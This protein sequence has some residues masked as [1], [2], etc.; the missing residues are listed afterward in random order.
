MKY[1]A[2]DLARV[3]GKTQQAIYDARKKGSL[4]S[5]QGWFDLDNPTNFNWCQAHSIN[6]LTGQSTKKDKS[7]QNGKPKTNNDLTQSESEAIPVSDLAGLPE[8][9]LSMT[10]PQLIEKHG[11]L[12][13]L[14]NY[15]D[16]YYKIMQGHKID[17][18]TQGKRNELIPRQSVD[19]LKAYVDQF[20]S[21]CFDYCDACTLDIIPIVENDKENAKL[22]IPALLK[23]ALAK[24]AREAV[25]K[26]EGELKKI[27][28]KKQV[29]EIIEN[30]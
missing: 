26:I 4:I 13:G 24:Y 5:H 14:K 20:L 19:F 28:T 12:A 7:G 15:V 29:D 18:E 17:I 3:S 10:I 8:K 22:R 2:V 30:D 21:Q 6:P 11:D 9:Y 16:I 1:R 23:N 25:R 27:E